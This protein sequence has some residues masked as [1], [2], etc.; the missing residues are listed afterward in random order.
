MN[1][2]I[3]SLKIV[4]LALILS[5]GI[6][7]VSAWTA[8]TATPPGGNTSAPLNVSSTAQTKVGDITANYLTA[9]SESNAPVFKDT[10]NPAYFVNP[11]GDSVL[12]NIYA[13]TICFGADCKTAWPS[14][15]V[16]SLTAGS[17]ISLSGSTGAVTISSTGNG[18]G[19]SGPL[20]P[21]KGKTISCTGCSTTGA[22]CQYQVTMWAWVDGSGNPFTRIRVVPPNAGYTIDSGNVSGFDATTSSLY[23]ESHSAH[24]NF[25]TAP[26]LTGNNSVCTANW[27][28]N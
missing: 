18:T 24:W 9:S 8:P 26:S 5:V 19:L 23:V 13:T 28:L 22:G 16:T 10:S 11:N 2:I 20:A 15:G 7:Y 14:A 27:P 17:G 6:S 21:L 25:G 3:N 12:A 1:N 4:S